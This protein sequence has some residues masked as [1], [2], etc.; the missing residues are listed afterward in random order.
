M[1]EER[2]APITQR[3]DLPVFN[4]EQAED[5]ISRVE[6]YFD[7]GEL[8]DGQKLQEVRVC[9]SEDALKWYK[10][11][12]HRRPFSS[13]DQLKQRILENFVGSGDLNAGQ[14]LLM[15]RQEGTVRE[16]CRDFIG[17]A[18]NAQDVPE[19]ILEWTFM[20]GLQPEIRTRV[21][22][23]APKSLTQMMDKAKQVAE[24]TKVSAQPPRYY[25]GEGN[26]GGRL[27]L[28]K[29]TGPSSG[30]GQKPLAGLAATKPITTIGA[31]KGVNTQRIDN[32]NPNR[33][34]RVMPPYRKLTQAEIEWRKAEG[35]CFRCDEKGHSRSQCPHKEYAV[36]IVQDDGSEIEW[37]DEGGE[38]K[39]EAILDTA[40]VAELSLNS[41][42]GISSPRTVKLRGSIRDEPVIVMIDSGAS[43]N[44]VSEK[45]VVKLGLTATETK[46]YGVVTGTG[47]TVQGRGVCKDVELHLQGLVVVAPF[48]PLELGSADVILGIQ[49]LGSLG[50][51]RCNWKLQKIAFMVEGKE[52]ELQGDPSICCSPV[53]LKGLWKAL[54][55]EGQGV[56]VEYGGL[57]AQNP[58]SEKPVPE[59][60]STVLAEFT[61]VFEEPRGLPPSRGKE[62]EITL[63]Q[64][65]SPVCVRPFRYPQAQREELERQVATMLAAGITKES[66]SPFSS[67]VLL[68][69]KKDGSWRFCVDYRALNKVTVG[70]SYPIPM[71]DQLL[72]ELHG[73]VIFSKLDLRAGYHQ[74]RVKAEDVPKTAFRTHDGHYEFLVMPF[75]LT[76]A[77]GTFQSLMNEVFRKFLRRFVLVFFDDILIYSKTE[78]EHQEHLR[79]VLKALAE[80][81]LVANRKKCEFGRVE[82]EY[83]GHVI[84]AKGV[85]A[86]PAKV[87][88]MVEW[89]S[90]GNIK[91]LR[92]FLGLTGYYR[93]F[94]K[95]YGEIAR[96]LTALL[97]KDQFKWSPAAEEA[98]KSLKIAMSTV[99]VLALVDFSVQFVVESDASGIGL[100]AVL[101]Q[102]QQPIAYFS[103]ALTERQRLKSVYERELMAIVFAI[104]KWRHYLL[105]RK[106]LVRTDQKSLKFLLEQREVN[107]EY[108]KWLTKILGFDFD[109]QYKPGMENKAADALSRVEGPQ[110]FALSMPIAIQLSEIESEVDKDEELSKLKLSVRD[111]P[112]KHPDYS[113]VQGRLLRKGR[114]VLPQ[115]SKLI[116]LILKEF[117]DG[118]MGGHGGVVKT[119]KGISAVFYWDKMMS[120][121]KSYV[122]ACQVCQRH[123][124]ST[125]T[126]AGLL[127]PLPIPKQVWEDFVEGLPKSEGFNVVMVVV[128][129][130]T[131]YAHFIK[132][133]HPFGGA[134]V[135][136][137]F[138]K[139]VVRLHGYP[140]TIVSDRD[141]VFTGRFWKDLFR[142]VGTNLCFSTA[143]HPQSD[144][145]TEVTNRGME[146]YLRCYCSE[147]LKKWSSYLNWA[148]FSYN[149]SHHKAI[150]MTPFKAV[151]GR[152]PPTLVQYENGSM[153]NATLE[154][155]LMERD[156]MLFI[157]QQ[158]L[159][160]TQQQMKQQADGHRR[161]VE[162]AVGDMVFL[163]VRPYRQK[164]LAR[165]TNE[166]LAARFYGP[167]EVEARVGPV[168]YKLK[169]PPSVKIHHTFH[170]SQLKAA[171]GSGLTPVT[172]PPQLTEEGVLE[173]EPECIRG[174]RVNKD[175]GQEEMLIQWK[176]LPEEDCTWEWKGVIENQFPE[177]DLEDKVDFKGG[178]NDRVNDKP[179]LLFQY[180]RK[181]GTKA[182]RPKASV[183]ASRKEE[184]TSGDLISKST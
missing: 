123:K 88:A 34:N 59:A 138:I 144:G 124:Y 148:E 162:F 83:L 15:L 64:E 101:M 75:G 164:T 178:S 14:R 60:L 161:E 126:P 40:E 3:L 103:Q 71:I 176:G 163:K 181:K 99:P 121:I 100:G 23:F 32:R 42:V 177:F 160:K 11:E 74:I 170:V 179:P 128:E 65:A 39:I 58:R 112:A 29:S 51:M 151:Y 79:L 31:N 180:R 36:L 44:F 84:S 125:L 169:F 93:K 145:Q 50:D 57:Q 147:Q 159:L 140:R 136:G 97:K 109:I 122:A 118:K 21:Q 113:V 63:K 10:W 171:L 157:M 184:D 129:R 46:G 106:F 45:M 69:K 13:W 61:G 91:A 90:P 33:M 131:K 155:Q 173:A 105:G 9:F 22:T 25:G 20:N 168:A 117:H 26:K 141:T 43:H 27:G 98:F 172:I 55:Q 139:E 102:Q 49:W 18:T 19:F 76:N 28:S 134:D 183:E 17:L 114:M 137:T 8:T 108:H 80:N 41:M 4:G 56:I 156:E 85:A 53:T 165:R 86:D 116:S 142:L 68:V 52:V 7:L 135:A 35:M 158:Q 73:S 47:L 1:P 119:Q 6:Q 66:N 107:M 120:E 143:Y 2:R 96:P 24:W 149:T 81:Q 89:P 72:D 87:Q 92:G 167:Y 166:K 5:W 133:S 82:I 16:Y 150:N 77:P 67:P 104:R 54:D 152:D 48:L 94:V 30:T 153:D 111:S 146:T 37:E 132:M 154:K 62:H 95:K 182:L 174:M 38:E 115:N 110:L 127:Q 175:S 78:V 70:D 12:K 130:L